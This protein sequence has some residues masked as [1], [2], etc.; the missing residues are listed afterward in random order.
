MQE[1]LSI[2]RVGNKSLSS[3]K[4][5]AVKRT[6]NLYKRENIKI[7]KRI[8]CFMCYAYNAVKRRI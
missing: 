6:W 5:K 1:V 8:Y 4:F 7:P 2:Y 3:N